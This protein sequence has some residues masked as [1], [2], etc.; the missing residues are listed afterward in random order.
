MSDE[1]RPVGS[2]NLSPF[3]ADTPTRIEQ[4][5]LIP[6]IVESRRPVGN[7]G[8]LLADICQWCF[9]PF[10]Y[11]VGRNGL[12]RPSLEYER[13]CELLH[14]PKTTQPVICE[15]CY[16]YVVGTAQNAMRGFEQPGWTNGLEGCQ[17]NAVLRHFS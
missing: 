11:T 17:P 10:T 2:H 15:P 5:V 6:K 9:N 1:E 8:D 3:G 12:H 7:G 16:E 13:L 14:M 4:P